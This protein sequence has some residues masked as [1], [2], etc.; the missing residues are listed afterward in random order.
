[1]FQLDVVRAFVSTNIFLMALN[2][3]PIPPLD[4]AEAWR[5]VPLLYGRAKQALA[6]R[7]H[8]RRVQAVVRRER[9]M[10]RAAQVEDEDVELTP[11]VKAV[12]DDLLGRIDPKRRGKG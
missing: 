1:V 2:L 9:Q 8:R 4:G 5:V 11:E 3:L 6:R 7:R 10:I 12:V